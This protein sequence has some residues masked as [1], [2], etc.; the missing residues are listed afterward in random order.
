M[1]C[2]SLLSSCALAPQQI[3]HNLQLAATIPS[4]SAFVNVRVLDQRLNSVIGSRGG[5]YADTATI[6]SK[7]N[8]SQQIQASVYQMLSQQG[9]QQAPRA[10]L[11]TFI[12]N[13]LQYQTIKVNNTTYDITIQVELDLQAYDGVKT[14]IS[15]VNKRKMITRVL[16]PQAQENQQMINAILTQALNLA[17]SCVSGK[18]RL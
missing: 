10:T 13:K 5:I 11:L 3:E 16:P 9:Y 8:L 7:S 1:G 12:I 18:I 17:L 15:K 2:I 6:T 14:Q 4:Q